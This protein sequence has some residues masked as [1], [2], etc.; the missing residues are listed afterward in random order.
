MER[1]GEWGLLPDGGWEAASSVS[2]AV[3]ADSQLQ[4][5][6]PGFQNSNLSSSSWR[7]WVCCLTSQRVQFWPDT[8]C[9]SSGWISPEAALLSGVL[10]GK[11]GEQTGVCGRSINFGVRHGFEWWFF[12]SCVSVG[13]PFNLCASISLLCKMLKK[14]PAFCGCDRAL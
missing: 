14:I 10:T 1:G 13:K 12:I 6:S 7:V 11:W 2:P 4:P 9:F 3:L 5:L 8:R